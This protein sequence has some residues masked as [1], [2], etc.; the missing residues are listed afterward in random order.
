M[1]KQF[2]ENKYN[3]PDSIQVT[4]SKGES[5]VWIANIPDYDIFTEADNF[6]E[7]DDLINDLVFTYFDV[8]KELQA[9]I[10]YVASQ[11]KQKLSIGDHLILQK[12]ISSEAE[13]IFIR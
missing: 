10:R 11:P 4:I 5:G 3:L 12:F 13:R 2:L 9:S 1:N 7:I 6:W 8:P